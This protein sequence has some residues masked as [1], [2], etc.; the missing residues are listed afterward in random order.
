MPRILT[1]VLLCYCLATLTCA[2]ETLTLKLVDGSQVS[3][4]PVAWDEATLT[5]QTGEGNRD[6]ATQQ[7]LRANWD[8]V[9]PKDVDPKTALQLT[10]GTFLPFDSFDVQS[11][12]AVITTS[13]TA[14]PIAISTKLIEWVR[15]MP[16]A[17]ELGSTE[18]EGDT[19]VIYNKKRDSFDRLDGV[20][21]DISAEKVQFTWDGEKVPVKRTK[22]AAL[23]YFHAQQ[24]PIAEP[25]CWIKLSN[26]SRLP[27]MTLALT[28]QTVAIRTTSDLE[29]S[30]PLAA[31]ESADYSLDKLAYLSDLKPVSE[32]WAPRIDLPASAE[33]IRQHGTPRR[34]Q[35][36]G[37]SALSLVWPHPKTG[38]LGGERKTYEKGLA[39]RSRTESRYRI[40]KGMTRFMATAG[41]DPETAEEGHVALE[42]RADEQTIWS[43]EIAGGAA[44]AEI[45]VVLGGARELRIL[46]D[47]GEN[48]D[49]GDRL[50]LVEARLSK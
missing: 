26:G 43:G 31:I 42:L 35:S 4:L 41:I 28:E 16:E 34:D 33:L 8:R 48:L 37:G 29:F 23:A 15:L 24:K 38:L 3:G 40:P 39:M 46:V 5:L 13:A 47:Y 12:E 21:G 10:D 9:N 44:P 22:V 49:F 25:I 7:L 17:P 1:L 11:R 18:L 32:R 36:Y 45:N 27:A 6:F 20:L 50:H 19:L 14:A 30:V 2:A